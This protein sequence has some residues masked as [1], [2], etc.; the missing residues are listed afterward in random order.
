VDVAALVASAILRK[1]PDARILPFSTDVVDI[2]LNPRDSIMTNAQKLASLPQGG[3][4]CSA[5]LARLNRDRAVGDLVVYVSDN[6]SWIDSHR[7]GISTSS[8]TETLKQWQQFKKRN[9]QARM[10]CIDLVPNATTQAHE[11]HDIFNVGG[12][13]DSVFR[14]IAD[15][16]AGKT[17][18]DY[19]VKEI[20]RQA[21]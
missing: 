18:K 13:S 9:P 7:R 5:P 20:E 4:N 12:F 17:E 1:N 19:W 16:A 2:R 10:I 14:F 8:P 3:T 11:Q 15:V 21:I 6:E